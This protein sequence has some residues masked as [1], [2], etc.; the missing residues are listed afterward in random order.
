MPD[1]PE[2]A[3]AFLHVRS[4]LAHVLPHARGLGLAEPALR[5][6]ARV[7]LN[8][9]SREEVFAL[10]LDRLAAVPALMPEQLRQALWA[11]PPALPPGSCDMACAITANIGM[12][13]T[14]PL[15][16]SCGPRCEKSC[17]LAVQVSSTNGTST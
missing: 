10:A 6:M 1:S 17:I 7:I 5:S 12:L 14:A 13:M 9:L 4:R 16:D 11:E 15:S 3:R 2:K 8:S